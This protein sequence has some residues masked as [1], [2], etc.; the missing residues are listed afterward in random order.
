MWSWAALQTP[1]PDP[2]DLASPQTHSKSTQVLGWPYRPQNLTLSISHHPKPILKPLRWSWVALQ[3]PKLPPVDLTPNPNDS[4][5]PHCP[6]LGCLSRG[7]VGVG[8]LQEGGL[9]V[10][11][12]S[13]RGICGAAPGRSPRRRGRAARARPCPPSSVLHPTAPA[14]GGNTY[15]KMDKGGRRG[16]G[17]KSK[18]N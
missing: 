15:N 5:S 17:K 2:K 18:E 4:G 13:P 3:T 8:G 10:G 1:E 9:T 6:P 7:G 12:S 16:G 14:P 11:S